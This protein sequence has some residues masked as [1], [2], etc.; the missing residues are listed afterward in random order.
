MHEYLL[1]ERYNM[2]NS[3][4]MFQKL[5]RADSGRREKKLQEEYLLNG[6]VK[7]HEIF[8][9]CYPPPHT[10]TRRADGE[11]RMACPKNLMLLD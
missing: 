8:R 4:R 7:K 3:M 6:L 5:P 2:L 11:G 9:T 1:W 10:H